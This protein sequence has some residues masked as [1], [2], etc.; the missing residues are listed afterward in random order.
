[1]IFDCTLSTADYDDDLEPRNHLTRTLT[2]CAWRGSGFDSFPRKIEGRFSSLHGTV[3][4]AMLQAESRN[5]PADSDR[6]AVKRKAFSLRG[7]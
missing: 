5:V 1:M 6:P 2:V 3:R 7:L 4:T